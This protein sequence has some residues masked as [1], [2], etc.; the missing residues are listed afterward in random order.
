MIIGLRV[1]KRIF[2]ILPI[3]F[4]VNKLCLNKDHLPYSSGS[5]AFV[6]H[7]PQYGHWTGLLAQKRISKHN[8]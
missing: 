2:Y 1:H 3:P 5:Q 6:Y 7:S 8:S 4:S